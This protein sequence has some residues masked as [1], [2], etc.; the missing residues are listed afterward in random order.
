MRGRLDSE[1]HSARI[2]TTTTMRWVY[3]RWGCRGLCAR[4]SVEVSGEATRALKVSDLQSSTRQLFLQHHGRRRRRTAEAKDRLGKRADNQVHGGVLPVRGPTI[5][6]EVLSDECI[7][8]HDHRGSMPPMN[9]DTGLD[10]IEIERR[11]RPEP[12]DARHPM[13]ATACD[14]HVRPSSARAV[15]VSCR[16]DVCTSTRGEYVLL[17]GQ[18]IAYC[19]LA[20]PH[21]VADV[22]HQ[23]SA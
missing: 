7:V 4:L 13:H 2:A 18:E 6:N 12:S 10:S 1:V 16:R 9:L 17:V 15:E 22:G 21:Q 11:D 3:A 23:V 19:C 5:G 8:I 20:N 14:H